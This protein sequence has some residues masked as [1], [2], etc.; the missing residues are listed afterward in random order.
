MEY[1]SARASW[2]QIVTERN[3]ERQRTLH[4]ENTTRRRESRQAPV[5][6]ENI[7][8]PSSGRR[9]SRPEHLIIEKSPIRSSSMPGNSDTFDIRHSRYWSARN[10][11]FYSTRHLS[12]KKVSFHDDNILGTKSQPPE[13]GSFKRYHGHKRKSS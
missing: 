8:R 6:F 13:T 10:E 12:S 3:E 4:T 9:Q 7:S 1:V 5:L 2:R 11:K